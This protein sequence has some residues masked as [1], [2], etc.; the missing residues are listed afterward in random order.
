MEATCSSEMS[1]DSERTK[2]RYIPEDRS[3][4]HR[5]LPQIV[6]TA[7]VGTSQQER[8]QQASNENNWQSHLSIPLPAENDFP[9]ST[10]RAVTT[11]H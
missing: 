3:H 7:T 1:V 11:A 2:W 5:W 8:R 10:R 9:A 6:Q 4:N